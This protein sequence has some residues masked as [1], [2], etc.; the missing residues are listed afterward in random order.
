M[1]INITRLLDIAC[2]AK[3]EQGNNMSVASVE[4]D[5]HIIMKI[6]LS[7]SIVKDI[8]TLFEVKVFVEKVITE[9]GAP[10]ESID[11]HFNKV[12]SISIIELSFNTRIDSLLFQHEVSEGLEEFFR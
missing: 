4:I 10:V 9:L 1:S 6:F 5:G 7:S 3:I 11:S 8:A 12:G 2:I